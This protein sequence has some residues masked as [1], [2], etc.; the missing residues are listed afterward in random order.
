M[1]LAPAAPS[2]P[3]AEETL[4]A[5]PPKSLRAASDSPDAGRSHGL[6]IRDEETTKPASKSLP[7]FST[8]PSKTNRQPI[9]TRHHTT[10]CSAGLGVRPGIRPRVATGWLPIALISAVKSIGGALEIAL[11]TL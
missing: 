6:S 10:G 11:P 7:F 9:S 8:P 2:S 3:P 1:S 4:S 5:K